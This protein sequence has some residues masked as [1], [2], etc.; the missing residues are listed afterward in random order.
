MNK[1]NFDKMADLN[2]FSTLQPKNI[3]FE[4]ILPF[5]NIKNNLPEL[6]RIR[7]VQDIEMGSNRKKEENS[8]SHGQ[9]SRNLSRLLQPYYSNDTIDFNKVEKSR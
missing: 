8:N 5:E 3:S 1:I 4:N 7:R 6:N 9:K 2:A